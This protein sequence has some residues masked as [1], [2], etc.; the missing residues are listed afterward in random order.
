MPLEHHR[1]LGGDGMAALVAPDAAVEWWCT[2]RLDS[3]PVLWRLLDD[4][5][6]AAV[7]RDAKPLRTV[8]GAAGPCAR[9]VVEVD[10]EPVSCWDG[11]VRIDD[12]PALIRLVRAV[13][14]P[15]E[16]VHELTAAVFDPTVSAVEDLLRVHGEGEHRATESG[17]LRTT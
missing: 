11:L 14:T 7:W 12:E 10:G 8:G 4:A 9:T 6:G 15:V 1:L 17:V 13:R 16:V 2:P 5:G 3:S